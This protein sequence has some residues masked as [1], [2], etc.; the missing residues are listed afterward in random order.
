VTALL[1]ARAVWEL[2]RLANSTLPVLCGRRTKRKRMPRT[3]LRPG[4]GRAARRLALVQDLAA[5]GQ[6]GRTQSQSR[7][8]VGFNVERLLSDFEFSQL[9][10]RTRCRTVNHPHRLK[11]CNVSIPADHGAGPGGHAEVERV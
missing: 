5:A 6:N 4:Q 10:D 1:L 2:P 8:Q 7:S 9:R 11:D 3:A